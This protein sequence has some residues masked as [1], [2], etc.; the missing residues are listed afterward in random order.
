MKITPASFFLC[1]VLM[2]LSGMSIVDAQD[3][4]GETVRVTT[5]DDNVLIGVIIQEDD[6]RIVLRVDGIGD[7]TLERSNIRSLEVIDSGRIKDGKYWFD[8][9]QGTRY[10]FAPN[11]LSL[12]K[13]SGYYQNTWIFFNN[14]NYGVSDYVSVGAGIVPL[15]L[16]GEFNLPLWLLPKVSIPVSSDNIHIGAG[17]LLG[18]VVGVDGGGFGLVYGNT[19]FGNR[20]K[21][22]T[23]GLGY[24]YAGTEWSNTPLVN[25]SGLIR[26]GQK[27]YWLAEIYFLPGIEGSGFGIFGARWAPERFAV[28]FGLARPITE[29][30][31]IIGVPWL[32]IT[33]PFGN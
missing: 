4:E 9:P 25:I 17:A 13:G 15:F 29:T 2:I 11:A 21:N 26:T 33:I 5:L 31:G 1:F 30:G 22:L 32:G 10:F 18:G 24:G 14:V 19:T 20:D 28:D 16:L 7:L 6:Q 23:L 12:N 3:Q 8:N 27:F